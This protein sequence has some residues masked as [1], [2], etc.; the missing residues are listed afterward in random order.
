VKNFFP[1]FFLCIFV[2]AGCKKSPTDSE[3]SNQQPQAFL[4]IFPN[5]PDSLALGIS[6]QHIHWWG[7]DAD[8]YVV[9]FLVGI[10][11]SE[12]SVKW[13]FKT[14]NDSVISFPLLTAKDTFLVFIKAIDNRFR[15]KIQDGIS[16]VITSPIPFADFNDDGIFNANDI[17]L[18]TLHKALGKT[19]WQKFP[20]KNTPPKV[21]F[22]INASN[23]TVQP[24]ETSFTV[25]TFAWRGNDNDGDNTITNYEIALNDTATNNWISID[26][27]VNMI[28]LFVSR[29]VSDVAT[30]SVSAE[31][32]KGTYGNTRKIG[33]V[34]GLKLND[35]NRI[36]LRAKDVADDYS[37]IVSLPDS[38]FRWFVKKPQSKLLAVED[39][40]ATS[41]ANSP[42][43]VINFYRNVFSQLAD[44]VGDSVRVFD[45][46][47]L[48]RNNGAFIPFHLDPAFILTLQQ[49]S[50]VFWY[51]GQEPSWS[52]ASNPL[53]QYAVD[54]ATNGKVVFSTAFQFSLA[55]PR[56]SIVSF[57]P[58]EAVSLSDDSTA[59]RA[60]ADTT[61]SSINA[62]MNFPQL[63]FKQNPSIHSLFFFRNLYPRATA[64]PIYQIDSLISKTNIK[65]SPTVGVLDA[66]NRFVFMG[67]PL[68]LVNGNGNL[69]SFF[70]TVFGNIFKKQ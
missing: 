18:A 13:I 1:I 7:E 56:G 69:P 54:P 26:S 12:S 9:G 37:P 44:S 15:E 21:T 23:V 70:N 3:L 68:H 8:G 57:A 38:G 59:T 31:V 42:D 64:V 63:Q 30:G 29:A 36:F 32:M 16:I 20:I 28:T 66:N 47:S 4:W 51:A 48:R 61:I 22:E 41:G 17:A 43:S 10:G 40:I 50:Y 25:I 6:K 46:L 58:I 24:P 33:E 45:F 62:T 2:F 52:I 60:Y 19:V 34:R 27:T 49:F 39:Y 5:N 11:K 35:T 14:K 65:F 55:D 67:V 53:F